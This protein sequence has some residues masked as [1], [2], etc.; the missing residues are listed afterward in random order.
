MQLTLFVFLPSILLSGFMFPF[1]GMPVVAQE[2]AEVLPLTHFVR[3][4]RGI[5]LRGAEL[6]E[7][8]PEIRAL[9]IFFVV[10][11][12]LAILRFRKRLD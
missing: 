11:L 7:L 4:I 1:D 5:V 12:T 3:L 2:I 9:I 10:S 8:V 6:G